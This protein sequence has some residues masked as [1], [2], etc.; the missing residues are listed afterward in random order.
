MNGV[1]CSS[2]TIGSSSATMDAATGLNLALGDIGLACHGSWSFKLKSWPHIPD[3]SGSVDITVGST[4]ATL[5]MDI[6]ASGTHP[7]LTPSNV[8]LNIGSFNIDF[9]GSLWDCE[10]RCCACVL[11]SASVSHRKPLPFR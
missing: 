10:C 9:H 5:D 2:F 4:S 3:G 11:A 6:S 7:F 1:S 8:A